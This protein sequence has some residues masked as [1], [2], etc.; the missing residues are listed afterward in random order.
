L[1]D[2]ITDFRQLNVWQKSHEIVLNIYEI[3]KKYPKDEKEGLVILMRR[4][5]MG[6]PIMIADGFMRRNFQD[7]QVS[8]KETQKA[9]EELKYYVILS[10]ELKYIK[11]G[12][13]L[14]LSIQEVGRMLTGLVRSARNK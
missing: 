2:R 6:I 1:T 12:E 9:L 4:A 3:T 5:A 11:D 10:I 14:L 7:K 13:E 8:Y